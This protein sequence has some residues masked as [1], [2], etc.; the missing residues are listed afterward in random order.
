MIASHLLPASETCQQNLLTPKW[1]LAPSRRVGIQWKDQLNLAGIHTVNLH[2]ETIKSL[3]IKIVSTKMTEAG[4]E[5]ASGVHCSMISGKVISD[6]LAAGELEYFHKVKATDQLALLLTKTL[7]EIRLGG[8]DHTKLDSAAIESPA[9]AADLRRLLVAFESE[10]KERSLVDYADCMIL[11]IK[12]LEHKVSSLPDNLVVISPVDLENCELEK[13]FIGRLKKN[14]VYVGPATSKPDVTVH[15]DARFKRAI[16]EVNEIQLMFQSAFDSVGD[17]GFDKI[18]I[19]H[20][21]Y[22]TYV[23]LIHEQLAAK[24]GCE[25][26]SIEDLPVT[27]GEGLACIYSRPGR[28]LRSWV[29]WMKADFLQSQI[30][31]MIREG[32]IRFDAPAEKRIGIGFSQL[33]NRLRK[34]P[35]GFGADRYEIRL[36][37][38][39]EI[40]EAEIAA[41]K[42]RQDDSDS[43]HFSPDYDFGK[44]AF[45]QLR[46]T[47]GALIDLTPRRDAEP[48]EILAAA[49]RFLNQVARYCNQL[50]GYA[51][52]KLLND[53]EGIAHAIA[54]APDV[55]VDVWTLL[56]QLPVKSRI[57]AS[58]PRPGRIH[59]DHIAKGGHSGRMSTFIVGLDDSRFPFRGG[60]DPLLLDLERRGI[61]TALP[62]ATKANV[63]S[64]E[65]L[66]SL[67]G[68]LNGQVTFSYATY[69]L[70]SDREQFP[71]A[72][73]LETYRTLVS[74]PTASL[75]DFEVAAGTPVSYCSYENTNLVS[76]DQWWQAKLNEEASI[77]K[78]FEHIGVGFPHFRLGQIADEQRESDLFTQ[79]DGHVPLAGSEL[80]PTRSDASRTSPS[81][82][83]TFGVCPRK[84][85]FRYGLGIHP[86]DEHVVDNE[87]WLNALQLG[88]LIHGVFEDFLR[89]LTTRGDVPELSRDLDILK[90]VLHSKIDAIRSDIPIPNQDAYERQLQRLE[91]SCEIFLRKE[92]QYCRETNSVPWIMEATIG[93]GDEPKSQLDCADPVTL[94]LIDG[95]QLKVGGRI[96]RIDR[97]GG[98][99]SLQFGIWD[100]KSGSAWKF[101][102]AS[103]FQQG[104]KLQP[105]LYAGM[106]R[107][108]LAKEVGPDAKPSFFGYFF[109]SPRTDGLRLQWTSGELKTGDGILSHI[110]DAISAG[111]FMATNDVKDCG[112]F[113]EYLPICGDPADTCNQSLVQ[114]TACSDAALDSM[115]SLRGI[116]V[117]EEPPW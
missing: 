8:L 60:Q 25:S 15:V 9:K 102:Q 35:I 38:A 10:L 115:R 78:R 75:H 93:L 74:D 111:A 24:L 69:S 52:Q 90:S 44:A 36:E 64:R 32:L 14:C 1:L 73:L 3:V 40:A 43:L 31:L 89:S 13:Q 21:D 26:V 6:L 76:P 100:Y 101:D 49:S 99:D 54:S 58:G 34:L 63:L 27:F 18:E 42:A 56:E 114:L 50:D 117:E 48:K 37:E 55:E 98:A 7:R 95:R 81:R 82:L 33:A 28:A 96:D 12:Q 84:F 71:S 109:P 4:V 72:A 108:R 57:L 70:A 105:F 23:P 97:V 45:E 5:F 88:S 79:F 107:H 41:R 61:S 30:V 46:E 17:S 22:S 67:L 92:E 112:S 116:E 106:L 91:K 47:V 103:P 51:R 80:D 68:R 94:T 66:Q 113:C 59:V 62:T 11:A 20:T 87:N 77:E 110:C 86:P 2:S 85:F 39:I 65:N 83:E 53:V 16:G 104:R 19:L 29:R